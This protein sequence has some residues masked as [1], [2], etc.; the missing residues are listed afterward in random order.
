[1]DEAARALPAGTDQA[2]ARCSIDCFA[3]SWSMVG[4]EV[5]RAR[6]HADA[7]L[8]TARASD[9]PSLLA[10]A[11]AM[12]G[13]SYWSVEPADALRALEESVELTRRG[14]SD[15]AFDLA[16]GRIA[17]LRARLGD[18]VG[19]LRALHEVTE[20]VDETGNHPSVVGVLIWGT[21]ALTLLSEFELA[22]EFAGAAEG[23]LSALF[24]GFVS[25]PDAE[26]FETARREVRAQLGQEAYDAATARG[27]GLAYEEAVEHVLEQIAVLIAEREANSDG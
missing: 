17:A 27:A 4:G 24:G 15:S 22:A 23:P 7:A 13:W 1:M 11:L 10:A 18:P 3:A 14:A 21:S 25:G 16:L 12:Y 6:R 8:R 2:F 26:E 19:A 9:V 5:G 20:H